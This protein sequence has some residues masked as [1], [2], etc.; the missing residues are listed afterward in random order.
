[1]MP[2]KTDANISKPI[3]TNRPKIPHPRKIDSKKLN[4]IFSILYTLYFYSDEF[5][6][7]SISPII[8]FSVK[9][10]ILPPKF[11]NS[12]PID[13]LFLKFGFVK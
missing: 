9:L 13:A 2:K 11:D 4:K 10:L 6:K 7:A 5:N 12:D 8:S 1:M 3:A